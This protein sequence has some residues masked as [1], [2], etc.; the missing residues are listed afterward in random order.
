M[1]CAISLKIIVL[2]YNLSHY[3]IFLLNKKAKSPRVETLYKLYCLVIAVFIMRSLIMVIIYKKISLVTESIIMNVSCLK[4]NETFFSEGMKST[5]AQGVITFIFLFK[6]INIH[7]NYIPNNCKIRV[8][9]IQQFRYVCLFRWKI[10][11][12]QK[13][14][15]E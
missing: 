10:T 15:Q 12:I 11:Q 5:S 13:R 14:V 3:L 6:R 2:Y 4:I 9:F 8:F 1:F 7:E